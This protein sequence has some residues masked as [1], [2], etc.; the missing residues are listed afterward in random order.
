M[1]ASKLFDRVWVGVY[2]T[3]PK[4]LLFST[5]ERVELFA[6][7]VTHIPNVEVVSFKGLVPSVARSFG[8]SFVVRGLRAGFDFETEFEM[9][10]MWR[11]LDPE[12][13]IVSLM[14][15]LQYQYVYSSRIKEVAQLG[16]DITDLVPQQVAAGLKSKFSSVS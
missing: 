9:A 10:L 3:P 1:R 16:G 7:A 6:D 13:D 5:K 4:R 8:A 15:S 11:K 2:D 14:S 12:V